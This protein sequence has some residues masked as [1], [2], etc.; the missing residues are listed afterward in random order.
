[1]KRQVRSLALLSGLRIRNCCELWWKLAASTPIRPL[2][3]ELPYAAD[4][5]LKRHIHTQ[6]K[7]PT[8]IHEDVGS[9][10]GLSQ[11]VKDPTLL[12][13]VA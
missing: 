13:V 5:A 7:N 2:A 1:M 8:S 9:I 4:A 12:Q 10:L 6:K 3:W 11:W